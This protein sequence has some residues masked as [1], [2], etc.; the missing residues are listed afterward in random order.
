MLNILHWKQSRTVILLSF[1]FYWRICQ[2][3]LPWN[4]KIFLPSR[5]SLPFVSHNHKR[6]EQQ[7]RK[8]STRPIYQLTA[9]VNQRG[10][11]VTISFSPQMRRI[12]SL[13]QS[14][15]PLYLS[16]YSRINGW[17]DMCMCVRELYQIWGEIDA[18]KPTVELLVHKLLR[19][20]SSRGIYDK[21]KGWIVKE[22]ECWLKK[23]WC[24]CRKR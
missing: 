2:K 7:Q 8:I 16:I 18:C 21:L 9:P 15:I 22:M 4:C 19:S 14:I 6:D 24:L 10:V 5:P 3:S 1:F 23:C 12:K 13:R 17:M 20:V 11:S